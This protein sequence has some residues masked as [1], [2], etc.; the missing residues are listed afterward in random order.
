MIAKAVK[1]ALDAQGM[2]LF[3]LNGSAAGQTVPHVH[4]HI[5]PGSILQAREHASA[6]A[7]TEELERV[8]QKIRAALA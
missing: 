3:Q 8:A 7:D 6:M 4:F 5:L 2:T 1:T